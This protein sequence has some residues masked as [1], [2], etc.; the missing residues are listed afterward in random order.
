MCSA[1]AVVD[2][3]VCVAGLHVPGVDRGWSLVHD[4]YS[5]LRKGIF[6]AS[7]GLAYRLIGGNVHEDI[8]AIWKERIATE[9][10]YGIVV[11]MSVVSDKDCKCTGLS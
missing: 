7:Q 2:D 6:G 9:N 10:T 3:E 1:A 5:P 4:A 8:I 11:P